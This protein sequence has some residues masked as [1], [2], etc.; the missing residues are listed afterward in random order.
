MTLVGS[1]F[2]IEKYTSHNVSVDIS[3]TLQLQ[4]QLNTKFAILWNN[5]A[6]PGAIKLVKSSTQVTKKQ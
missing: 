1:D 3:S 2:N 4:L 5:D 6:K